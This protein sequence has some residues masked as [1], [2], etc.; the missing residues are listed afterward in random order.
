MSGVS[1]VINRALRPVKNAIGEGIGEAIADVAGAEGKSRERI[2]NNSRRA[3][4]VGSSLAISVMTAD[5]IGVV[6]AV[7]AAAS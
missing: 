7:D 3:F 5:A 1:I 4:N 2:V 6:D